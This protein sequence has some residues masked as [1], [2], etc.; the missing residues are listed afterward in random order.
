MVRWLR[1][2]GIGEPA[3]WLIQAF[4]PLAIL[5]AQAMYILAPLFPL[6]QNVI[7]LAGMLEDP[8]RRAKFVDRLQ[9][10][11]GEA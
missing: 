5:G 8:D 6:Q 10:P 11:T 3:A 7:E 1:K 2:A 9:N 4:E